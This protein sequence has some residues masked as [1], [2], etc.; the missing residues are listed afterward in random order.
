MPEVE[1]LEIAPVGYNV[2][3][4]RTTKPEDYRF[5][6]GQATDLSLLIP[7]WEEEKRPFSFTSLPNQKTLEFT[8]KIY[9]DHDGVTEQLS[10]IIVGQKFEIG[11]P[12][13]AIEYRGPGIFIAG[14]SGLTP[15]LGIL[16]TLSMDP[17]VDDVNTL[18]FANK[19]SRDIFC[20]T[21]L[22]GMP[23]VR[24]FHV[25]SEEEVEPHH[26]GRIDKDFLAE[27]VPFFD[28]PFYVCGPDQMVK[29][30]TAVLEELGAN[31]KG[32]VFEK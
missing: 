22:A 32:I 26:H 3:Q 15:F 2:F 25:L 30:V 13:G 19:T 28:Q 11:E 14:G 6:P 21:D 27:K 18:F 9:P 24:T 17:E 7:G 4:F 29:D 31:P 5:R 12:W 1:V 10:K 23:R 8:I 16:R 20:D